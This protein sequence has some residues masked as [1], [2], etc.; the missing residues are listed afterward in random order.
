MLYNT[1]LWYIYVIYKYVFMLYNTF[2]VYNTHIYLL[3]HFKAYVWLQFGF[4]K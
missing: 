4:I 3:K 1:H 2:M